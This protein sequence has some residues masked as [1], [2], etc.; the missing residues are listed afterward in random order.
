MPVIIKLGV[1]S[2]LS[3]VLNS[4]PQLQQDISNLMFAQK[5]DVQN[6]DWSKA[7]VF[8]PSD[9][10]AVPWIKQALSE[11]PKDVNFTTAFLGGNNKKYDKNS[12]ETKLARL[13]AIFNGYKLNPFVKGIESEIISEMVKD[14][15]HGPI[16]LEKESSNSKENWENALNQGMLNDV[17]TIIIVGSNE[18]VTR[19][20]GTL[21]A[22]LTGHDLDPNK[23]NII[24]WPYTATISSDNLK[25][26]QQFLG[27]DFPVPKG[28]IACNK[29][30]W[31]ESAWGL[32]RTF[33]EMKSIKRY[34]AKGDVYLTDEQKKLLK[35]IFSVK[36]LA[37]A[38]G[39]AAVTEMKKAP[40]KLANW[41][42]KERQS[43]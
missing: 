28:L 7:K 35:N 16:E 13:M 41:L 2:G 10:T 34:S 25:L 26:Y 15:L 21:K 22:T 40:K 19:H 29:D 38:L 30:S 4:N 1:I 11:L 43:K 3:A 14:V 8:V 9:P 24:A 31:A 20:I 42:N 39:K 37:F 12:L 17:K 27:V 6:I 33:I 36:T 32:Y 5:A 18:G 23:Y